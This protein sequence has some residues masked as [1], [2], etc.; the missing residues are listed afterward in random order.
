MFGEKVFV[1]SSEEPHPCDGI[2]PDP[3]LHKHHV[4]A[5]LR[6]HGIIMIP[7]TISP[8]GDMGPMFKL[9]L[10][11]TF[12]SDINY[13]SILFGHRA[14]MPEETTEAIMIARSGAKVQVLLPSTEAG[15]HQQY[16]RHWFG[17]TYQDIMPPLPSTQK[18]IGIMFTSE[19]T[20]QIAIGVTCATTSFTLHDPPKRSHGHTNNVALAPGRLPLTMG[21]HI[22]TPTTQ[23]FYLSVTPM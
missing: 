1:V 12:P 5:D 11:G 7:V 6:Q 16:G 15:W 2:T 19:L 17:P 18:N 21:T 10:Y 3:T 9:T 20:N 13:M 4:M 22:T 8:W 23:S 14:L